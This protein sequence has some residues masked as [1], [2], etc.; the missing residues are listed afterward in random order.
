MCPR[1][2]PDKARSDP[3]AGKSRMVPARKAQI[4]P[5]VCEIITQAG[6]GKT[7]KADR[8]GFCSVHGP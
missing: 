8:M 7:R 5:D 6:S 2:T 3:N 1:K 4:H